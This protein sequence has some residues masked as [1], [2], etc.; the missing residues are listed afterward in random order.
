MAAFESA[1]YV[2]VVDVRGVETAYRAGLTHDAAMQIAEA[3]QREE[4]IVRVV[5]DVQHGRFE[6]DRY[7]PR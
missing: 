1:A 2:V 3:L 5:H 4:D 6:V 7:P